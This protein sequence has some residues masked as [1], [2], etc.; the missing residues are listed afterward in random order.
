MTVEDSSDLEEPSA[1]G[2]PDLFLRQYYVP[3]LD[4]RST[5]TFLNARNIHRYVTL[6]Q[7]GK[8]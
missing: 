7:S 5:I 4:N 3:L 2:L 1:L 8:R 6:V